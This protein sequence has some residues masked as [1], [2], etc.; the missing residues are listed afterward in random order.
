MLKGSATNTA[1]YPLTIFWRNGQSSAGSN[2]CS[3]KLFSCK[4]YD[5]GTL[6]RNYIPVKNSNNIAGVYDLVND[7]FTAS[8]VDNFEA[9]NELTNINVNKIEDSNNNII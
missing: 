5:D 2:V 3:A 7:T 1:N 8:S 4:I 9:G 6:V